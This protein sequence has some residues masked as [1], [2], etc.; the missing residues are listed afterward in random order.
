M[1]AGL[2]LAFVL[3]QAFSDRH[4]WSQ[5]LF[6]TPQE[7]FL[8][9]AVLL[10]GLILI[11]EP[12]HPRRSWA[13]IGPVVLVVLILFHTA[14][15]HW[16]LHNALRPKPGTTALRVYHWN[17]TKTTDEALQDFLRK[18]DPFAQ[19]HDSPAVVVLVNAPLQLNWTD[20]TRMLTAQDLPKD[21]VPDH[22]RR[23]GRF[24]VISGPTITDSG[25]TLLGLRGQTNDPTLFDD[26]TAVFATIDFGQDPTTIWGID[27]PSDPSQTRSNLVEPSRKKLEDSVR[28]RYL[29]TPAGPLRREESKGFPK[30]GIA[31]GDFNTARRSAAVAALLP[32]MVSAHGQ[33]GL[34]PG[35]TWP[36][37][38]LYNENV[39]QSWAFLGLDQAYIRPE[40]WRARAYRVLDLGE[41]THK[42]QLVELAKVR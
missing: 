25:W 15:V 10:A 31:V 41:G 40:N 38:I 23:G 8:A 42:A 27:W 5:K 12:P 37:F 14:F 30:P 9:G 17:A 33:A 20:I 22:L 6:W 35:Y 21:R 18:A 28:V 34:G 36:R 4:L 11:L 16:R 39:Y 2:A 29:P 24:V 26:G 32:G 7:A 13:R 19:R 1:L 3:G